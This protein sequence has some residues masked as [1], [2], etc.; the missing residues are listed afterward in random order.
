MAPHTPRTPEPPPEPPRRR[1]LAQA[2]RFAEWV[3][4]LVG[5]G[6]GFWLGGTLW[7]LAVPVWP[8]G[9]QGFAATAGFLLCGSWCLTGTAARHAKRSPGRPWRAV[10]LWAL[11]AV[12]AVVAVLDTA[13][14][15]A[16]VPG[17]N[18]RM[19]GTLG[20]DGP[21]WAEQHTPALWPLVPGLLLGAAALLPILRTPATGARRRPPEKRGR[22]AG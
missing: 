16:L 12:A 3:L 19:A 10:G 14:L 20:S 13:V 4:V 8:W 9:G 18:G 2:R 6:L 22:G 1:L 7:R 5:A 11:A 15:V 21:M 17:R